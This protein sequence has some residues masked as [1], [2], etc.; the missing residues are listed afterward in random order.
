MR[1]AEHSQICAGYCQICTGNSQICVGFVCR[2]LPECKSC[3]A[4]LAV[5]FLLGATHLWTTQITGAARAEDLPEAA[6]TSEE[7]IHG[8]ALGSSVTQTVG[9]A[10]VSLPTA[11]QEIAGLLTFGIHPNPGT[12]LFNMKLELEESKPMKYQVYGIGGNLLLSVEE[13]IAKNKY[14]KEIDLTGEPAGLYILI[15]DLGGK[16]LVRKLVVTR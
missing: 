14:V 5:C 15:L 3:S 16:R 12:G 1:L 10:Q 7:R 9:E 8:Q 11:T 6:H 4:R 2:T 13:A